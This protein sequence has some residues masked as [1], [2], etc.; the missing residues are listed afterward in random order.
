[1]LKSLLDEHFSRIIA[2]ASA[3]LFPEKSDTLHDE[4][5]Q[6]TALLIKSLETVVESQSFSVLDKTHV[7]HRFREGGQILHRV[8][9]LPSHREADLH[10]FPRDRDDHR[11]A[12]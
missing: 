4:K 9:F 12:L 2:T 1:M 7:F 3:I 6:R 8:L 10:L 11:S 5:R